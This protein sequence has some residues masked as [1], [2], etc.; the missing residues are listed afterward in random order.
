MLSI[1]HS[2]GLHGVYV[3]FGSFL[4]VIT[5]MQVRMFHISNTLWKFGIHCSQKDGGMSILQ[6]CI[7][8]I[9]YE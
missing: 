5:T 2:N 4:P 3:F 1:G 9:K 6:Q 7:A 8:G